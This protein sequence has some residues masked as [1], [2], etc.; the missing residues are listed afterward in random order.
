VSVTFFNV[1]LLSD[2]L[3]FSYAFARGVVSEVIKSLKQ[4]EKWSE[5]KDSGG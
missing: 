3:K 2:S 4:V 1:C 5:H